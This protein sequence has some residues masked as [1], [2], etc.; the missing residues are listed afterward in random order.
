MRTRR[1]VTLGATCW[2]GALAS[3]GTDGPGRHGGAVVT[4]AEFR[5]E[6]VPAPA[7]EA[8][9]AATANGR[10]VAVLSEAEARQGVLDVTAVIG[11]T[12]VADPAARPVTR[13]VAVEQ[14]IGQVNGQPIFASEILAP[15]EGRLRQAAAA[16]KGNT[17]AWRNLAGPVIKAAIELHVQSE[18]LLA[19]VYARLTP[20]QRAEGLRGFFDEIRG[21]L[22]RR[23]QGSAELAEERLRESE[24]TLDAAVQDQLDQALIQE[25]I[26]KEI[27]ARVN[28]SS[29][30][31]RLYYENNFAKFNPPGT[32]RLRLIRVKDPAGARRIADLLEHD[33]GFAEAAR[34]PENSFNA[35]QGGLHEVTVAG[36]Y[37]EGNFFAQ[38]EL[39]RA[40][41]ALEP[42]MTAGP[43]ELAGGETA[44]VHLEA[45]D[46]P[47]GKTLY[48]AQ[49][50]ILG[51]L[52]ETR[53]REELGRYFQ[54]VE[55]RASF[56]ELDEMITRLLDI[57][58]E[59]YFVPADA[60]SP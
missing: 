30:D 14:L 18:V 7:A 45:V 38:E 57:A 27:K 22:V 60:P 40:A 33:S 54:R 37:A 2:L 50:Q 19:E 28:V 11:A 41:R 55:R 59:R 9:A 49:R 43:I 1:I 29:R 51:E 48:E 4:A 58:T 36:H 42:G 24:S 15:L 25:Q 52:T 21:E 35:A 46:R 53:L 13:P 3:C 39:N 26:K 34:S 8:A 31:V 5:G 17:A 32:A 12:P 20:Q 56:T 44:W 10:A 16:S 6:V 23:N 47:P